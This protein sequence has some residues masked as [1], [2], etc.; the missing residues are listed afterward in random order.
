MA[1]ISLVF[2]ARTSRAL[3]AQA[4][5]GSFPALIVGTARRLAVDG[6]QIVP[7]GPEFL[8]PALEAASEQ[9]R[10]DAVD[11]CLQPVGARDLMMKRENWRRK[12]R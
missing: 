5:R 1:V 9:H 12:S 4:L 10:I 8:D 6:D 11:Q 7:A 3:V 2:C